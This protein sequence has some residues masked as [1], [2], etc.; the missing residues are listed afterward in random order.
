[1]SLQTKHYCYGELYD[2]RSFGNVR[3]LNINKKI[4]TVRKKNTCVWILNSSGFYV[5]SRNWIKVPQ[6][7]DEL[8]TV[9]FYRRWTILST[10][11]QNFQLAYDALNPGWTVIFHFDFAFGL[12]SILELSNISA[13]C[14][15]FSN[16]SDRD[17]EIPRDQRM[18]QKSFSI[19]LSFSPIFLLLWS[20]VPQKSDELQTVHFYRRWTILSTTLQNFQ[21]AYDGTL[22]WFIQHICTKVAQ[23]IL[24]DLTVL[25]VP[26][27]VWQSEYAEFHGDMKTTL[28]SRLPFYRFIY[29]SIKRA[30]GF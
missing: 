8:Q 16:T 18:L 23:L 2:E 4:K 9:H 17:T 15:S 29:R 26:E 3:D 11:L 25:W 10:I 6:K 19:L 28:K 1:M 22:T 5:F 13:S 12:Y 21:L 27:I 7:S 24:R 30:I 14:N 20:S